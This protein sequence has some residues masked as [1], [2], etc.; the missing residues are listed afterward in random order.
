MMPNGRTVN[1]DRPQPEIICAAADVIGN[2]GVVIIPTRGLYG[3]GADAANATAVQRIFDIKKRPSHKPLL[4]LI[5]HR[6]MLSGIVA[7]VPPMATYLMDLFWPGR[8]TLVMK[9]REDLPAG[10]C[11]PDGKVGVRLVSHPVAAALVNTAE[12]PITGTSANLSGAGGASQVR[13]IDETVI[14]SVDMVL[15]AGSLDGGPGSTI[16]DVTVQPPHILRRGAVP[17]VDLH[18]ALDQFAAGHRR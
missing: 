9:G 16:V 18:S 7:E 14:A 2:N 3:L 13:D 6:R 8:L 15:D 5:G 12:R 10:L 1:P 17:A 11:S 4:V